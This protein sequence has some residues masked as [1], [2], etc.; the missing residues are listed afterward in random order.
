M[1][2]STDS[3][4]AFFDSLE[5]IMRNRKTVAL[6][7]FRAAFEKLSEDTL[8]P[9]DLHQLVNFATDQYAL[10]QADWLF[11]SASAPDEEAAAKMEAWDQIWHTL[12]TELVKQVPAA[13]GAMSQHHTL[14]AAQYL[15]SRKVQLD[16]PSF[17]TRLRTYLLSRVAF[18]LN[19]LGLRAIGRKLYG[20][21]LYPNG[22]VGRAT[23]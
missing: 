13:H 14:I 19:A 11:S 2:I 10:H 22:T 17:L 9:N 8:T 7:E 18:V 5:A 1:S 4:S 15:L 20:F 12:S 23:L 21:A 16:S 3:K 6:G